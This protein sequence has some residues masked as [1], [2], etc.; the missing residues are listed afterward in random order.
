VPGLGS[1]MFSSVSVPKSVIVR[2]PY[3]ATDYDSAW[4]T[5]FK[6]GNSYVSVALENY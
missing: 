6:G 2:V 1:A 5:G 3:G 4:Q